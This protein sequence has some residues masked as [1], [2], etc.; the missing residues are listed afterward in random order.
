[1]YIFVFES[2]REN[3]PKTGEII[4]TFLEKENIPSEFHHFHT[5]DEL[6]A[7]LEIVK[8]KASNADFQ[9]IV[10]FDCHGNSDG[11][12]AIGLDNREEFISW[13]DILDKFIEI[14]QA[15]KKK[16][17]ISMSSCEGFN[18]TKMIGKGKP[19]PY[20]YVCGS[21]GKISFED[22][23]KAFSKFY[24]NIQEGASIF[25]AAVAIHNNADL[26]HMNFM[27]IDSTTLFS[28]MMD[29]YIRDQLSEIKLAERKAYLL[30]ILKITDPIPSPEQL[31]YLDKAC[32][33]EGHQQILD[34]YK[35]VFFSFD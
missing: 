34:Y 12:G 10:H 22:S 21:F 4:Q 30:A 3:D 15:S 18:A 26:S 27:A 8:V 33:I 23:F 16:S 2:L 11:I 25:D 24:K 17:V 28:M 1:M 14:Y 13:D 31:D 5:R 35:Y 20:N 9:P 19:C 32:S 7:L 29:G 6:F